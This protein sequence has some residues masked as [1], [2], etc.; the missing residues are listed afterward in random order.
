[1]IEAAARPW[2]AH[3]TRE[4]YLAGGISRCAWVAECAGVAVGFVLVRY[5]GDEMEILNLAVA[6]G[7]RR[8]GVGRCLVRAALDE[9]RVRGTSRAFL[10]VR[11]SNA[12]ALALYNSAGFKPVGRR[13]N[14]YHEPDE[15]A[16]VLACPLPGQ[17][18]L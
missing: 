6:E 10:E 17:G 11:E 5:V 13:R 2:T 12:P 3:W 9:A 16:L 18:G 4:A 8:S 1:M 7:S 14:Y 15:D